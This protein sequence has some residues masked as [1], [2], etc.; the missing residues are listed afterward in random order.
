MA[1]QLQFTVE[2]QVVDTAVV[3]SI[4]QVLDTISRQSVNI[5]QPSD[6][7]YRDSFLA[8]ETTE[9]NLTLT[10]PLPAVV[11]VVNRDDPATGNTLLIGPAVAGP[12][13]ARFIEVPV[14]FPFALFVLDSTATLRYKSLV[15][16]VP[17]YV[18]AWSI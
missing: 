11:F 15:A 8:D 14:G 2:G 18:R 5:E 7:I 13:L 10:I 6:S 4:S 3:G 12:A 9:A 16:P 17:F 1:N